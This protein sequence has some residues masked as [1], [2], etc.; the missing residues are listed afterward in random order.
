MTSL[1]AQKYVGL[2]KRFLDR[3]LDA[4]QPE[5]AYLAA[6]KGEQSLLPAEE[7]QVR[8]SLF[9]AVDALCLDPELSEPGDL[10][11]REPLAKCTE[12]LAPLAAL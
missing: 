10:D 12:A 4:S 2:I 9:A 3:N 5:A 6:F 7:F 11:E 8:D 1:R